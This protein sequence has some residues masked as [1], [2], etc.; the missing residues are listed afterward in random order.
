MKNWID[1]CRSDGMFWYPTLRHESE[2]DEAE[3]VFNRPWYLIC[4]VNCFLE[5]YGVELTAFDTLEEATRF[6]RAHPK[7]GSFPV[8]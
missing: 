6:A 8:A 5:S 4:P 7:Y 2:L 1:Y 3:Q